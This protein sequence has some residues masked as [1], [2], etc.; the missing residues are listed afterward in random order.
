MKIKLLII[1]LSFIYYIPAHAQL[2]TK[3]ERLT[4]AENETYKVITIDEG[5]TI[6]TSKSEFTG[7]KL[8]YGSDLDMSGID[9]R[10]TSKRIFAQVQKVFSD[11]RR[12]ELA[13]KNESIGIKLYMLPNGKIRE[14]EFYVAKNRTLTLS[15]I[16][17]LDDA[18]RKNVTVPITKPELYRGIPFIVFLSQPIRFAKL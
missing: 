11:E 10:Q 5:T 3:E 12:R 16:E 9:I 6:Q 4:K 14:I 18:I 17:D 8:S 15:E 7:K 2:F 13:E 1:Q